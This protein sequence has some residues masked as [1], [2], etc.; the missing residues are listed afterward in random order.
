[1]RRRILA[2]SQLNQEKC[3]MFTRANVLDLS[4]RSSEA[5]DHLRQIGEAAYAT[6]QVAVVMVAGGEGTRLGFNGPKGCCPFQD[7]LS[8]YDIHARKCLEHGLRLVIMT[9]DATDAETRRFF[10]DRYPAMEVIFFRQNRL[11]C[12][13]QNGDPLMRSATE[14][15]T[16]P[17]GHG[18]LYTAGNEQGVFTFLAS[19]GVRYLVYIQVDNVLAPVYDPLMVGLCI[20][21]RLDLVTKVFKKT[22]PREKLG[23]FVIRDGAH[24]VVEYT[25]VTEDQLA[26]RDEGGLVFEWGMPSMHCFDVQFFL[27]LWDSGRRLK[28]HLSTKSV[29][30][31]ID[32]A[33]KAVQGFKQ[34]TFIFDLFPDAQMCGLEAVRQDEFA[35]IKGRTGEDS[36]ETAREL[37]AAFIARQHA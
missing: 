5:A 13:D 28:P 3:L 14:P 26:L 24:C 6:G 18:G 21:D 37:Y 10:T 19:R 34:E 35:P 29:Q 32:G 11:P 25:E 31:W 1:M 20:R 4:F 9:S 7:G 8:L 15:L 2:H 36:L 16:N 23:H 17:D 30:A 27:R 12:L 22:H 33:N